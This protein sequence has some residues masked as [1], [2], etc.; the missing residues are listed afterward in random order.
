MT[1][2]HSGIAGAFSGLEHFLLPIFENAPHMPHNARTTLV[3]IAPWIALIF[4][5]L[6]LFATVMALLA[7]PMLLAMPFGAYLNS[8]SF[9]VMMLSLI[10]GG[11]ACIFQLLAYK[12][13]THHKKKGWDFLFFAS[14]LSAIS[15]ILNLVMGT[16][17][18]LGIIGLVI[19]YWLLFEVRSMYT[20]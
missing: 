17:S 20:A 18:L 3:K 5:V 12:P 16:G 15:M 11:I 2:H 13:L 19:G 4:G 10:I 8:S 6:G 9:V 7:L 1:A 14:T